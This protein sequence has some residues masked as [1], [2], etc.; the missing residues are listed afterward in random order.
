[1]GMFSG[2]KPR[3]LIC[4]MR[5]AVCQ[6]KRSFVLY[7]ISMCYNDC[8]RARARACVCVC[9]YVAVEVDDHHDSTTEDT[10]VTTTAADIEG[11]RKLLLLNAPM[12][13]T[14]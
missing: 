13:A 12:Y 2:G 5:R 14:H 8:S 1:M 11:G 9:V 6:Q 7:T 4:T 3:R 10:V